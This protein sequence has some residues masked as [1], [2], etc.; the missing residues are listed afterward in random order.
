M[1][2]PVNVLMWQVPHQ[3]YQIFFVWSKTQAYPKTL[4]WCSTFDAQ[5]E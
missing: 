1:G 3:T 5:R 2:E 4:N